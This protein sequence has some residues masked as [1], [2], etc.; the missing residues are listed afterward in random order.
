MTKI[1]RITLFLFSS[2]SLYSNDELTL[3]NAD[4][5]P[6][7]TEPLSDCSFFPE[8]HYKWSTNPTV[9]PLMTGP[10][11]PCCALYLTAL[12]TGHTLAYHIGVSTCLKDIVDLARSYFPSLNEPDGFSMG[13]F[14]RSNMNE[15]QNWVLPERSHRAMFDAI[16]KTVENNC[17][18]KKAVLYFNYTDPS[19][20]P[21]DRWVIYM[22][23][24]NDGTPRL[25][26]LNPST[27]FNINML[28]FDKH[29]SLSLMQNISSIQEYEKKRFTNTKTA[30]V[31]SEND[32]LENI[33]TLTSRPDFKLY[34]DGFYVAFKLY[35]E[36]HYCIVKARTVPQNYNW[37][38][39][40]NSALLES[41]IQA[42]LT[43]EIP[44]V[45]TEEIIKKF[46]A[47]IPLSFTKDKNGCWQFSIL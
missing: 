31:K 47:S 19:R 6:L 40:E 33:R 21:S 10:C 39:Q 28:Q 7:W 29:I 43:T 4:C 3:I 24:N 37:A 45:N 46:M 15:I 25:Y 23:L 30:L 38:T 18:L 13:L 12:T 36:M 41:Y 22:G 34:N 17:T 42:F 11:F 35:E 5:P 2:L 20:V 32:G 1:I 8:G 16:F 14:T 26:N 44:K 27:V 9:V